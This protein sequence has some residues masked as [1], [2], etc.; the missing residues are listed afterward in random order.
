M[1]DPHAAPSPANAYSETGT[2]FARIF[3][4]ADGVFSIAATLLAFDV[5]LP[6]T[7]ANL[8]GPALTAALWALGPKALLYAGCFLVIGLYWV[9]HHRMFQAFRRFDRNLL[10]LNMVCLLCV[11]FLPVP[12]AVLGR[13]P[14]EPAAVRF[15]CANVAAGAL[16]LLAIWRYAV[17]G[18]RAVDSSLPAREDRIN[19]TRPLGT[20]GAAALCAALAGWSATAAECLLFGYVVLSFPIGYLVRRR[21]Q[22]GA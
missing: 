16:S 15:Y 1:I 21:A 5:K 14:N 19:S 7:P 11:A 17:G 20:A 22:G 6:D 8:S 10:W 2:D 3:N 4:F 18:Q 9:A 12:S 13:Y